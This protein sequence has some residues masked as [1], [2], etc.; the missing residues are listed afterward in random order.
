MS[1]ED[2]Q[3]SKAA[4]STVFAGIYVYTQ[5]PIILMYFSLHIAY[6]QILGIQLVKI[7]GQ[8]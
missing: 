8:A 3:S 2:R 6:R 4:G 1:F 5:I 7:A